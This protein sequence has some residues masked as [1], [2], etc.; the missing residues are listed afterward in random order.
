VGA[1]R[2]ADVL[3]II[4]ESERYSK[5]YVSH[6]VKEVAAVSFSDLLVYFRVARG[7]R[8]LLTTDHTM[9][10]VAAASGFS[11]ASTSREAS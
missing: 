11:D 7:E 5:S 10:E 1:R 3:D 4:A 9:I 2:R 8:I 6:I